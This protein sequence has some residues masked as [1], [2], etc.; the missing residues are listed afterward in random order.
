MKGGV[1]VETKT[2]LKGLE[3]RSQEE[4]GPQNKLRGLGTMKREKSGQG[5]LRR[6][7][8]EKLMGGSGGRGNGSCNPRSLAQK[9]HQSGTARTMVGGC[10]VVG[11][12]GGWGWGGGGGVGGLVLLGGW[13]GVGGGVGGFFDVRWG[14]V[15]CGGGGLRA[16]G[17]GVLEWGGCLW[18]WG[19]FLVVWVFSGGGGWGGGGGGVGGFLV[20]LG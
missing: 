16:L 1:C 15:G 11:G 19:G 7:A 10:G 3:K 6:P 20:C 18:G 13:G 8:G 9:R 2:G 12:G 5:H 14:S 17:L 4:K